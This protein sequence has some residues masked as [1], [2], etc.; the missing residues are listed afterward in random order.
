MAFGSAAQRPGWSI[1]EVIEELSGR[2][3]W[4]LGGE[5]KEVLISA[6]QSGTLGRAEGHQVVIAG[7]LGTDRRWSWRVMQRPCAP[8]QGFTAA[9]PPCM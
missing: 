4:E 6:D 3:N 5:G 8:M 2:K 9:R 1:G 7:V